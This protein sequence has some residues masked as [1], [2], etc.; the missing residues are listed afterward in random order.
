[1]EP[2]EFVHST[3]SNLYYGT[4]DYR[5]IRRSQTKPRYK[6]KLRLRCYQVPQSDTASFLEI[7]KKVSGVVYKRRTSLPYA[8]ALSYLEQRIPGGSH[9]FHELDWMLQAYQNLCP[10]AGNHGEYPQGRLCQICAC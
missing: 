9:I 7:K 3:I 4:P 5:M 2:D 1:M 6:E 10:F 8:Q